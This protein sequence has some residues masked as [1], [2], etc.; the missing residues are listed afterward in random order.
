ML[1][2]EVSVNNIAKYF[3]Q[4]TAEWKKTIKTCLLLGLFIG[5]IIGS[6]ILYRIIT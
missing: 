2:E 3:T 1:L 5:L 6:I 4:G